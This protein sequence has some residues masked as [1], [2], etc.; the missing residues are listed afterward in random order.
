LVTSNPSSRLVEECEK[1]NISKTQHD[2]TMDSRDMATR[3]LLVSPK[4]A[5]LSLFE[6]SLLSLTFFF[7]NWW[8]LCSFIGTFSPNYN[9]VPHLCLY[10]FYFIFHVNYLIYFCLNR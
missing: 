2:P 4:S 9:F 1:N 10:V 3:A 7:W 5:L 8:P 6:F